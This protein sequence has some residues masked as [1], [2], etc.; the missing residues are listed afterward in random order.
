MKLC[1]F[2][3]VKVL[4]TVLLL[5]KVKAIGLAF[6]FKYKSQVSVCALFMYETTK[7][8]FMLR[9]C[10]AYGI[11]SVNILT[12]KFVN[13]G[14]LSK[15]RS[16]IFHFLE[17]FIFFFENQMARR[18]SPQTP[19]FLRS[20][21]CKH[22]KKPLVML[23]MPSILRIKCTQGVVLKDFYL[24]DLQIQSRNAV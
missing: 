12:N 21:K 5:Q 13:K 2:T 23:T 18:F 3:N 8:L 15:I 11:C 7:L 10:L 19:I 20:K 1:L 6:L 4:S 17:I 22:L 9:K 14:S 24:S 16:D